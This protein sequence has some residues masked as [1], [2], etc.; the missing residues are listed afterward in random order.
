MCT[1]WRRPWRPRRKI[2]G[3]ENVGKKSYTAKN[4]EW[5]RAGGRGRRR[6]TRRNTKRR[7][8]GK[9]TRTRIDPFKVL[10][11]DSFCCR[12]PHWLLTLL[13]FPEKKKKK[14]ILDYILL[15]AKRSFAFISLYYLSWLSFITRKPNPRHTFCI[16]F[17]RFSVY[18]LFNVFLR[19]FQQKPSSHKVSDNV[20][21][22]LNE[23]Q[24]T[25]EA[26]LEQ[27]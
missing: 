24:T 13:S 14:R 3:E 7:T 17:A 5:K 23:Q 25:C 27:T 1:K 21:Y 15:L 8:R 9:N 16:L 20:S 10:S 6:T 22:K 18:C 2:T 26:G 4:K 11:R 19:F 12:F